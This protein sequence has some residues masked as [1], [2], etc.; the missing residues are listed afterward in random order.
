[1]I[2]K[3]GVKIIYILILDIQMMTQTLTVSFK[4]RAVEYW[5]SWDINEKNK[6]KNRPLKSVQNKLEEFHLNVN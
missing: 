5:Q 6:N 4:R 1:M 3:H 2:K